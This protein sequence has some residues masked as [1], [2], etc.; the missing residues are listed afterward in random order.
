M[1]HRK[2]IPTNRQLFQLR[3]TNSMAFEM[4]LDLLMYSLG[5]KIKR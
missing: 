5:Y 3:A 4:F 1:N 2:G